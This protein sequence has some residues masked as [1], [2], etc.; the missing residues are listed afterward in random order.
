M[1]GTILGLGG[2]TS[3]AAAEAILT[4]NGDEALRERVKSAANEKPRMTGFPAARASASVEVQRDGGFSMNATTSGSGCA[5]GGTPLD[6]ALERVLSLNKAVSGL[7]EVFLAD[8]IGRSLARPV[9]AR[10]DLPGFDQSAMDG[11]AVSS[12]DLTP[13][14]SLPITGRT[15]AG[16]LPG[17]VASGSAHRIL[18]GAPLPHGADAVI[19]QENVHR[20]GNIVRIAAT[21]AAGANV[22]RRG[23]DIRAGDTLIAAG[24]IVDWRHLTVLAAQGICNVLVRRRPRVTLL[25]SGKELREPG[26]S[27]APGQ[28]H[29]SNMPMLAALLTAWGAAVR[30]MPA[31][32][33]NAPAMQA[34]LRAAAES[35]DLVL[36]TAGISVGDEDHVRDALLAI[37]GD[38][39]V[40]KVAMKPGKPL[41]AG[42]LG[43]AVF[44]GLPGNPMAALAGAVAFVRPLLT[45]MAGTPAIQPLKVRAAFDA[46]REPGRAEFTPIRLTRR[47]ECVWA[48]RTGPGGSGRLAS[49]LVSTGFAFLPASSGDVRHGQ[50]LDIIPFLSTALEPGTRFHPV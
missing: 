48:E 2:L 21:V 8:C 9:D 47:N 50:V 49:L 18:T 20:N 41:A 35:S 27:L 31:V 46:R 5:A 7:E 25:S 42:R 6:V 3:P 28:I 44:I 17:S 4:T 37:G 39:T 43:D 23:E 10:L 29:D 14:G 12:A 22:K 34:A 40:L 30:L 1:P 16:E 26:E 36:S 13:D 38:L 24:T 19:A 15:A 11:Y 45:Q 33:D 32:E